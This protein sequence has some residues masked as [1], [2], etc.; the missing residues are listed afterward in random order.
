MPFRA[1]QRTCDC[2]QHTIAGGQCSACSDERG[3]TLQRS[4]ISHSGNH[5]SI[6]V[7]PIVHEGLSSPGQPLDDATRA[8]FE[9]RSGRDF[10]R[11]PAHT[12]VLPKGKV[13]AGDFG[14][15]H[16]LMQATQARTEAPRDEAILRKATRRQLEFVSAWSS[17]DE[18][19][20]GKIPAPS[21]KE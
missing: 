13:P 18:P 21:K 1:L 11:V 9:P 2:G 19:K 20:G 10:S 16:Q 17:Y 5:I 14:F 6:G 3:S 4:A 7:L 15:A 12:S 8:F